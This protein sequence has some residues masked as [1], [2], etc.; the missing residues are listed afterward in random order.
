MR[1]H[2]EHRVEQ[3]AGP[4]CQSTCVLFWEQLE[5]QGH[6][7][8]RSDSQQNLML[9]ACRTPLSAE[10]RQILAG[11]LQLLV[12]AKDLIAKCPPL[13]LHQVIS[14]SLLTVSAS[15]CA[16]ALCI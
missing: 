2:R 9:A 12:S 10:D 15:R 11:L 16:D 1:E 5:A 8:S 13:I 14:A 6:V 4:Q 7:Q 3:T